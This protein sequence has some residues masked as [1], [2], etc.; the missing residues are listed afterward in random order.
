YTLSRNSELY[1]DFGESYHSNDARGIT[2]IDDPVTHR[3]FDATGARVYQI[4]P[5]ARASGSELGYRYSTPRLTTTLSAFQL[6]L[7][8]ELVFDGDHGTTDASGPTVRRGIELANFWTPVNGLTYDA[9]FATT[10]ARFLTD[11]NHQGTGVPES[12]NAVI[13]AG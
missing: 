9:D 3:P 11:P 5:L 10:T 8:S 2:G 12:L 6:L 4:T 7:Q 13:A 1:A